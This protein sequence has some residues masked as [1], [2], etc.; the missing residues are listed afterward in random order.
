MEE[1]A[2]KRY[3]PCTKEDLLYHMKFLNVSRDHYFSPA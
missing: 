1:M 2:W 3:E